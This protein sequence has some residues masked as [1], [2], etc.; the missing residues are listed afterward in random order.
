MKLL[1]FTPAL[2]LCAFL[3]PFSPGRAIGAPPPGGTNNASEPIDFQRAQAIRQKAQAGGTVTPE[4]RAYLQRAVQ[5]MQ[6]RQARQAGGGPASTTPVSD[7]KI[8]AS[9]VPLDEL[10]AT[11]KGQDGGLYG[12][13]LNSPPPLHMSAYLKESGKIQPLDAE[14]KPAQDGKIVLLS[15][16][17]SNT[18]MEYSRFKQLA[19]A[20][21][22]KSPTVV[23]VD[24]AQNGRTGVA[25]PLG[26]LS[27]LPTG[28]A[29]RIKQTLASVGRDLATGPKD[30]WTNVAARLNAS[31]VTALQV[32]ALWIKQAE[33][34]PAKIG[35]FPAHAKVLQADIVDTL[36]IA[37][38][39]YPNLRVAYLS[40][41]IFGGYATMSLNPEP[42]AYEGAFAMRWVILDQIK[43]EPRLNYDP[44]RG[45]VQSPLVVWGPYLWA[46]GTNPRKSDGFVWNPEDFGPKDHTHPAIS[47]RQKVADLLLRFFKTDPAAKQ[48]FLKAKA[49]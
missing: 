16:G 42:Y 27:V 47:A 32:Q 34:N 15:I 4:E 30:T 35:D 2:F 41:R 13:G 6:K 38:H 39:Y 44:A 40:S 36:N 25:W 9:L 18:T 26:G 31:G 24:G 17:M 21:P 43:G 8:V 11:Y 19:D 20:D 22:D 29:E 7:P 33:A 45:E 12:G 48:W 49:K 46:N 28:E 1:P 14:G 37:K 10:T 5:E 3:L 23:V